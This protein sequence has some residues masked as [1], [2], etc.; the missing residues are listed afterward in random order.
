[1]FYLVKWREWALGGWWPC[2]RAFEDWE[3]ASR[4]MAAQRPRPNLREVECEYMAEAAERKG[5]A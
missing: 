4:F 1:M 2:E 5:G 3:D